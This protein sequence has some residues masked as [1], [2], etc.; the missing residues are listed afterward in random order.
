MITDESNIMQKQGDFIARKLMLMEARLRECERMIELYRCKCND[1]DRVT[2]DDF[3]E[4]DSPVV[5]ADTIEFGDFIDAQNELLTFSDFI[6]AKGD[7]LK[8]ADYVN[9]NGNSLTFSSFVNTNT[10]K[11]TFSNFINTNKN[12][13]TFSSFVD[14]IKSRLTFNNFINHG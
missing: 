6:D 2:F 12:S 4:C 11:L 9:A 14:T 13:M 7:T 10:S 1:K 8:F 5:I 3:V